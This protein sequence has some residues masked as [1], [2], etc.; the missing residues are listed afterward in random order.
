MCLSFDEPEKIGEIV[1]RQT[2]GFD[3]T[4]KY[5][6]FFIKKIYQMYHFICSSDEN[7]MFTL[8]GIK[9]WSLSV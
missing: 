2:E 6:C 5:E 8:H 1:T 3:L 4:Q 9:I 7:R